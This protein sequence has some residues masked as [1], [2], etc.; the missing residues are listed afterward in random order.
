M[1]K[2]YYS[3]YSH[4]DGIDD[5]NTKLLDS[6]ITTSLP[7]KSRFLHLWPWLSHG[8]LMSITLWFFIQWARS[9][10]MDDVVIYCTWMTRVGAQD[11][12]YPSQLQQTR[13]LNPSASSNSTEVSMLLPYIV[14][15][16]PQS[17]TPFG[18]G[19]LLMVVPYASLTS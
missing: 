7:P 18:I 5:D 6:G 15:L 8:V 4:L 9:P 19:Y 2:E 14:A 16:H 1:N 10:S 13:Q 3:Q 17:S 12:T 11:L